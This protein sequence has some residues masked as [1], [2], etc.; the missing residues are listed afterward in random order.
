MI[1]WLFTL[2][3]L[4]DQ[5]ILTS[6]GIARLNQLGGHNWIADCINRVFDFI[7][8]VHRSF[9]SVKG[10]TPGHTKLLER[11]F[12]GVKQVYIMRPHAHPG[13][14]L[15]TPL[16]TSLIQD[17]AL[18][19]ITWHNWHKQVE[20]QLDNNAIANRTVFYIQINW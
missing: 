18:E 4:N 6:N 8:R 2:Q 10:H 1:K 3:T 20:F 7:I 16:L 12:I 5:A 11:Q 13:P 9:L 19:I 17:I 14:P 15:A